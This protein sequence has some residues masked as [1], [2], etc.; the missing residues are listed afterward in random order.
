MYKT[1][2]KTEWRQC[3]GLE[4]PEN[5]GVYRRGYEYR[6]ISYCNNSIMYGDE[7]NGDDHIYVCVYVYVCTL[8]GIHVIMDIFIPTLCDRRRYSNVAGLCCTIYGRGRPRHRRRRRRRHR[9]EEKRTKLNIIIVVFVL[10]FILLLR[11]RTDIRIFYN[12]RVL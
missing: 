3:V 1:Q 8:G 5:D 2:R 10:L 11:V 12:T 4:E 7:R 9:M 6:W